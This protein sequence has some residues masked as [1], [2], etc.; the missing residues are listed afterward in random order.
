MH[1]KHFFLASHPLCV[2]KAF[3]VN[4]KQIVNGHRMSVFSH[5]HTLTQKEPY[6]TFFRLH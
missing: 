5:T 2:C 1:E 4:C 3:T 6:S